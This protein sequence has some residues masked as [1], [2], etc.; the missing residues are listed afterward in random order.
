MQKRNII[1]AAAGIFVIAMTV[2]AF[3]LKRLD[4]TQKQLNNLE[5]ALKELADNQASSSDH[6]TLA[7]NVPDEKSAQDLLTQAVSKNIP[8]VV[9]IAITKN[10]PDMEVNYVNPFEKNPLLKQLGLSVPLYKENGTKTQK[11]GAGTGFIISHDG[12][13]LTNKHVVD[14]ATA[15]YT[16]LLSNGTRKAAKVVYRDPDKDIAV[17]KVGGTYPSIVSIG[18]SSK[19]KLGQ[20]VVAIGN[21][22]G[23]YDNTISVGIISGLNRS[24]QASDGS[25]QVEDLSNVIQTDAS[26]NPGNSGGPLI[27]LNGNVMGIN[28][29]TIYG[30]SN[31]SFA[32]PINEVKNVIHNYTS[33]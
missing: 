33:I 1:A 11:I 12:Y 32:L 15:D 5:G 29:A 31:I 25:G 20:T 10:V 27:D 23:E 22:L 17:I 7:Q 24:I 9:S 8:A 2:N 28:V 19:I 16:V 13:I 3:S 14:D 4:D 30:S 21:A 18:D 6:I 26:I